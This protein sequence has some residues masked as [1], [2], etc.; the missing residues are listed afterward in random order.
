MHV[1]ALSVTVKSEDVCQPLWPKFNL[2][3][4]F[5]PE[6]LMTYKNCILDVFSTQPHQSAWLWVRDFSFMQEM[7]MSTVFAEDKR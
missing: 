5:E 1:L 7:K 3:A 4:P 6:K 2:F